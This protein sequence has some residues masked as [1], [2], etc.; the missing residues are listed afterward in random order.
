MVVPNSNMC[1]MVV[2]AYLA[3][4]VC[5]NGASNCTGPR[6]P[7]LKLAVRRRRFR[8]ARVV[9]PYEST[10]TSTR[11]REIAAYA[12]S[13]M[14]SQVLPPTPVESTHVGRRPMYSA[15]STGGSVPRPDDMKPWTSSL[16]SPASARAR[17]VAWWLSSNAVL[18]STRPMSE[19]AAP[20]IATRRVTRSSSREAEDALGDDVALDLRAPAGDGRGEAGEE[21]PHPAP[22]A[23]R[24]RRVGDD[25]RAA[26]HLDAELVER[27][28]L[29][30]RGQLQEA[31]LGCR[32]ALRVA[33]EPLVP[34]RPQ[35]PNGDVG[36]GQLPSHDGIAVAARLLGLCDQIAQRVLEPGH[37]L[38]PEPAALVGQRPH[39]DAPAVVH[40]ADEV[41]GRHFD[42][43]EE[44]L[45][46]LGV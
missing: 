27:L 4:S 15:T 33:R 17:D 20:T 46:E 2:N 39:G 18:W 16:V 12:C 43:G 45:G 3:I 42:V 21:A 11:P 10:T 24:P 35:R 6:L 19:R 29:L 14:N 30:A 5:P 1:R 40:V 37:A 31:V 7:K 13:T 8:S 41:G 34:E 38:H 32:A 26:G 9:D 44:H 36:L 28:A 23:R 25:G 22:G